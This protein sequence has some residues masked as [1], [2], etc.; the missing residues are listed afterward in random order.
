MKLP[1]N[2]RNFLVVKEIVK[3]DFDQENILGP[4]GANSHI[5]KF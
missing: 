4:P 3:Q 1:L 2:L 5:I